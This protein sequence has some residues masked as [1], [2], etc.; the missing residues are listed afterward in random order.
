MAGRGRRA[1]LLPARG[2]RRSSSLLIAGADRLLRDQ[3]TAA[4]RRTSVGAADP[5]RRWRSRS[6]WT[7]IPFL[8][9]MVIFVWGASV[10][11]AHGA[12]ARR[13]AGH[14]RRRQAV[15]VEVPAPRRPARDQRA[16]RAGRPAGQ[17]DH[18][19]RGRASTA[20]SSR[21]SASRRT[22]C[23]GRYTHHLVRGR[24]SRARYH[25]FCAEYCGTQPLGDDRRGRRDGAGRVPGVA[26]RRRAGGIAGVGAASKLFSELACDT[27][28]RADAQGRGPVARRAVRQDGARCRTARRS[29]PTRTTSASRS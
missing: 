7:V 8:I 17:A 15:D 18:D 5:R 11:F 26:E 22:S 3:A 1:V 28:H 25:L 4:A 16:A 6:T 20:S 9:A 19:V 12:A 2:R 23:P 29:R 13:D 27:C 14:L 24:R 10:F 21:R